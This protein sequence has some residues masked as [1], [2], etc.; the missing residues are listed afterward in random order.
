MLTINFWFYCE[1]I[2][3]KYTSVANLV[4][5]KYNMVKLKIYLTLQ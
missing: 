5:C 2:T 1:Y 3:R 4:H